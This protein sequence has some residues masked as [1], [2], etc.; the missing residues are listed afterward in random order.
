[1]SLKDRDRPTHWKYDNGQPVPLWHAIDHLQAH[2]MFGYRAFMTGGR[3]KNG[4][5]EYLAAQEAGYAA[6]HADDYRIRQAG[7]EWATAEV[8]RLEAEHKAN[9]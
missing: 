5:P 2:W 3:P 7:T 1:M 6:A 9:T 8:A 4:N